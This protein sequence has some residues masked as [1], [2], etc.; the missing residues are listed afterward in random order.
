MDRQLRQ[1][2]FHG[3]G[4][5]IA[6]AI[7]M[8]IA[9]LS[10]RF[11]WAGVF[12]V[13]PVMISLLMIYAVMGGWSINLDIGTT[14]F[15]AIAIGVGVDFAVHTVDRLIYFIRDLKMPI[16]EAYDA[17]YTSTGRALLFNL[18]SLALGFG[19]LI[20]SSVP[21]LQTFGALV[22]L[23][24]S[25][26]FIGSMTILPAIIWLVKPVFLFKERKEPQALTVEMSQSNKRQSA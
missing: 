9:A 18:L 14:M 11:F 22:A 20:T 12:T 8:L 6:I 1:I 21:P 7:V 13:I 3:N 4:L 17:F 10:F 23:A 16:R 15:A 19:V 2:T 5:C 24:V 25:M 26:S